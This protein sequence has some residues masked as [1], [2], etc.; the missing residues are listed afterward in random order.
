MAQQY[1]LT[2]FFYRRFLEI[3]GRWQL[4]TAAAAMTFA[5]FHAPNGFLI[6][7]TLAAGAAACTLYRRVPNVIALALAHAMLSYV[8]FFAL[9][10]SVTHGLRVG[11]GYQAT[12]RQSHLLH[13]D[14]P[15]LQRDVPSLDGLR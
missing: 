8:L 13:N 6:A 10:Q 2:C 7:V 9:P 15:G 5:T 3:F 1:G 11:P 4:A 12:L 14:G